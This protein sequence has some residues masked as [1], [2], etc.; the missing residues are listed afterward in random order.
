MKL[1]PRKFELLVSLMLRDS[2]LETVSEVLGVSSKTAYL[3]R[4]KLFSC[5]AEFQKG[6]ILSGK[7]WG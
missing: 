3:W 6:S 1:P 4:L 5:F 7:V 2:T